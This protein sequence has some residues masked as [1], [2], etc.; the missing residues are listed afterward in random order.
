[1]YTCVFSR[2]IVDPLGAYERK[3]FLASIMR[4]FGDS[5]TADAGPSRCVSSMFSVINR[6][7][8]AVSGL[9]LMAGSGHSTESFLIAGC[10]VDRISSLAV[11]V[12]DAL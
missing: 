3:L 4:L 8:L 12:D 10:L 11:P 2:F 7:R 9:S 6:L 5:A 1:M